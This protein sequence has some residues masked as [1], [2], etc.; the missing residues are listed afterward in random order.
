MSLQ[1][2]HLLDLVIQRLNPGGYFM[3]SGGF[4]RDDISIIRNRQELRV[5]D[6]ETIIRDAS[7]Y[8]YGKNNLAFVAQKL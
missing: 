6:A 7:G 1:S 3:G 8:T 5:L 2:D 4:V